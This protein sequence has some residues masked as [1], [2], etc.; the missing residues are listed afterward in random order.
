MGT[1]VLQDQAGRGRGVATATAV[2]GGAGAGSQGDR[3]ARRPRQYASTSARND[4]DEDN[5]SPNMRLL[6]RANEHLRMEERDQIDVNVSS[7]IVY[8]I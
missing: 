2:R 4:L 7:Y 8:K 3:P 5:M 1:V 6:R